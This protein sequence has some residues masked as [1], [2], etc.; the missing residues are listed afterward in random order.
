MKHVLDD[1]GRK[2]AGYKGH[3]SDCVTRAISIALG[4]QGNYKEVYTYVTKHIKESAPK[5]WVGKSA[6]DGT[7]KNVTKLIMDELGFTW[8][9]CMQIG[10]GCKVHLKKD[11]LP[12]GTLIVRLSRHVACVIDGVLYDSY[13]S[14][15]EG[16]RCV[17]GYWIVPDE[18]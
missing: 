6:R 11:E 4:M 12:K 13:D 7:P 18:K 17:Y 9:P 5:N 15:R 14:H 2:A 8:V 16:M 3:A 1:G 10:T